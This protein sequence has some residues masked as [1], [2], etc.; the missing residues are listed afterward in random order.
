MGFVGDKIKKSKN[1]VAWAVTSIVAGFGAGFAYVA[2][3]DPSTVVGFMSDA[4]ASE[5]TRAGFFFLVAAWIHSGRMKK[6]IKAN[7]V[8]LTDA[9]NNVAVALRKDL[10]AQAIILANHGLR[11]ENLEK[12]KLQPENKGEANA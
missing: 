2:N 12:T 5:I 7:F 10:E 9:I 3:L 1:P 6:E 4:A 11:L 8:S